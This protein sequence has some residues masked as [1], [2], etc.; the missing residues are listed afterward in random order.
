MFRNLLSRL[1]ADDTDDAPL[2]AQDAEVAIAALLVRVARADDRYETSERQRIDQILARRRGLNMAEAAERLVEGR[3]WLPPVL[4]TAP[5]VDPDA[6][7][8]EGKA[9]EPPPAD[10]DAY[11]FA[12]E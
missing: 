8:P 11:R 12:A 9:T 1:F 10:D 2:Q 7:E 3:G 6:P 4:R 5:A